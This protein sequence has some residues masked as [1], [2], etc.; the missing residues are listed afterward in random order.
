MREGSELKLKSA[1][2]VQL[3]RRDVR[4]WSGVTVSVADM[5]CSPGRAWHDISSPQNRMAIV[6][7]QIGGRVEARTKINQPSRSIW[8]G[9]QHIDYAPAG[10]RVWGYTN[11]VRAIRGVDFVFEFPSLESILGESIDLQQTETPRLQFF[12]ERIFRIGSLLAA[13]CKQP[14]DH[15][16]LYGDSLVTALVIGFLRF[17]ED[18]TQKK[19]RG[20]LAPWQ[21]Q[22]AKEFMEANLS[23]G[24]RLRDL[25]QLTRLSQS[26]FGRA[27]KASTGLAPHQWQ[28]SL[29]INRA[30]QLIL[31]GELSLAQIALVTGFSEQSHF[32]RVFRS[33]VGASPGSWRRD[34]QS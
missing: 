7:E 2:G 28:M 3:L 8:S 18:R 4:T 17:A 20:T 13:E 31:D 29:R 12:D 21:L 19:K 24:V 22:R 1:H 25:A 16:D 23:T 34:R 6:L 32:T 26:Q 27:F 14:G 15:C 33:K 11:N 5:S 10:M 9:P 30:Q